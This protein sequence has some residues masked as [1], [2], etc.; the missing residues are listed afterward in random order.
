MKKK[1]FSEEKMVSILREADVGGRMIVEW[2]RRRGISD[3]TFYAWRRKIGQMP[4]VAVKRWRGLEETFGNVAHAQ[5]VCRLDQREYHHRRGHS[6]L[7]HLAPDE[8]ALQVTGAAFANRPRTP[9]RPCNSSPSR[10]GAALARASP[11]SHN[12]RV[13]N[14][15]IPVK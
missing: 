4:K 3:V 5:V 12:A 11:C 15:M 7:G 9:T 8:F 6:S 1:R 10:G 13:R 14:N 2:C